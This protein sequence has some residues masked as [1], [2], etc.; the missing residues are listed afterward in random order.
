MTLLKSL[1]QQKHK[2]KE[3]SHNEV[4]LFIFAYFK[5]EYYLRKLTSLVLY[6]KFEYFK[7]AYNSRTSIQ[8]KYSMKRLLEDYIEDIDIEDVANDEVSPQ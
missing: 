6:C 7:S 1:L 5:F 2:F 3:R 4:S 8:N